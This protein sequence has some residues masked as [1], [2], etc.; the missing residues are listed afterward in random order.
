MSD[1]SDQEHGVHVTNCF[2]ETLDVEHHLFAHAPL[3]VM[4]LMAIEDLEVDVR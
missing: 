3:K 1:I 2:M 4:V